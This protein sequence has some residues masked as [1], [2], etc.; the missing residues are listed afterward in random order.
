MH[1]S[2]D[3]A[4]QVI[5]AGSIDQI[6]VIQDLEWG[7]D[8][9]E[10]ARSQGLTHC[11]LMTFNSKEELE[12]YLPHPKHEAFKELAIPHIAKLTVVDYIARP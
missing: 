8:L 3:S 5:P 6:D 9:N 11:L 12:I 1:L 2:S 10:G 7:T 4:V